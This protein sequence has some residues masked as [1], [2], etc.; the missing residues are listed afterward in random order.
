MKEIPMIRIR[1][2]SFRMT[3]IS[4]RAKIIRSLAFLVLMICLVLALPS[5]SHKIEIDDFKGLMP[6]N[7]TELFINTFG[8]GHPLLV[9][10][11]GPGLSHDYFMPHLNELSEQHQLIFYDQRA[12]GRSSVDQKPD[13]MKLSTFIRDKEAIRKSLGL[14]K[15]G[16]LSHSWGALLATE[17]AVQ[18]PQHISAMIFVSPVPMSRVYQQK[19]ETLALSR[20]DEAFNARRSTIMQSEAFQSRTVEGIEE[21]FMHNFSLTFSDTTMLNLLD[22]NL[23]DSFI[24]GN[25]ILQHFTG[26]ES[27]DFFPNLE[28]LRV[29]CLVIRGDNDIF[30]QQAD[31]EMIS[32]L[33]QAQLITMPTGHFPFI[34]TNEAFI[35]SVNEFLSKAK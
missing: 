20:M 3:S 24:A 4:Q 1:A 5:C 29:P 9:I 30:L 13:S 6:I 22:L 14:Q 11:G 15:M 34:E 10:H 16:V 7:G 2:L 17:Y 19:A 12:A 21:L 27:Y 35:K 32:A 18:Y 28:T 8:K 23:S 26:L 33:P 25:Q 31:D